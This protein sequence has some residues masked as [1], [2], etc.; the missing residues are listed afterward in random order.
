MLLS[1]NS[2]VV[3]GTTLFLLLWPK[4][5]LHRIFPSGAERN[6]FHKFV[7]EVI[8]ES[9]SVVVGLF[10]AAEDEARHLAFVCA[11][12]VNDVGVVFTTKDKGYN[13]GED[14]LLFGSYKYCFRISI[15]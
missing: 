11:S 13:L 4:R 8:F 2:R 3:N 1:W 9:G 7:G 5:F 12:C 6:G 10:L 15:H 14:L